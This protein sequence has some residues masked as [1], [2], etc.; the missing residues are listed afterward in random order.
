M[1]R[2]RT[3]PSSDSFDLIALVVATESP[4]SVLDLEPEHL[5]ILDLAQQPISVAEIAAYVDLPVGVIRILLDDLRSTG[6]VVVR[7]PMSVAKLPSKRT[8]RAV[9]NGL[10]AL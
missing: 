1:T 8:L 6:A 7:A 9:I 10:H 2:G 5:A 4:V 3:K